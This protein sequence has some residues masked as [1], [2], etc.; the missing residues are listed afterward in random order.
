[1]TS[2]CINNVLNQALTSYLSFRQ[3]DETKRYFHFVQAANSALKMLNKV[4][5]DN[6]KDL[7][8][9]EEQIIFVTNHPHQIPIRSGGNQSDRKP[10]IVVTTVREAA[11]AISSAQSCSWESISKGAPSGGKGFPF[12]S[13]RG[14]LSCLEFKLEGS[15]MRVQDIHEVDV[16]KSRDPMNIIGEEK[17]IEGDAAAPTETNPLARNTAHTTSVTGLAANG[18]ITP[19]SRTS[20]MRASGRNTAG[21]LRS[22]STSKKRGHG[23][24][25]GGG[26]I[27]PSEPPLKRRSLS[28]AVK[29]PPVTQPTSQKRPAQDVP[30]SSRKRDPILQ[31]ASYAVEML[32]LS[33]H[34]V[35][36]FCIVG[37]SLH[38]GRNTSS[39]DPRPI[40]AHMAL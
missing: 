16:T 24:S 17:A 37:E 34:H 12:D 1:M 9:E 11:R 22:G 27:D 38:P 33:R 19:G 18:E 31:T 3:T 30:R 40:Y 39:D 5:G 23:E 32:S 7:P 29:P 26:V 35:L 28:R 10:D 13:F 2:A 8:S 6:F 4:T 15:G 25:E 20:Q 14:I 21:V 36:N